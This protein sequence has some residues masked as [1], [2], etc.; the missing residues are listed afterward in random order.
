MP[1]VVP[2]FLI[3]LVV[4]PLAKRLL[5]PL[6]R[7]VVTTSVGVVMEAKRAAHEA[8]ESIH[9]L[10][11]EVAADVVA[12]RIASDDGRRPTEGALSDGEKGEAVD[13]AEGEAGTSKAR[14]TA[15]AGRAQTT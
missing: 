6:V 1:P 14:T 3:G 7:G 4:A 15:G 2:P 10:A 5:E 9:D 11:A 12:A 8:G 13:R